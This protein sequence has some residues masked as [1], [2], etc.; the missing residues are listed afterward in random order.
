MARLLQK[1]N[2]FYQAKE[3]TDIM[4][5][6][7][8]ITRLPTYYADDCDLVIKHLSSVCSWAS[9]VNVCICNIPVQ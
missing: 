1:R 9:L 2:T 5:I 3:K 4:L 8:V 6:D 7:L